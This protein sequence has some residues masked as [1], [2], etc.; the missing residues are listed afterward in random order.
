MTL[1]LKNYRQ[2]S[3]IVKTCLREF[4]NVSLLASNVCREIFRVSR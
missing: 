4:G 3:S 1:K 2:V